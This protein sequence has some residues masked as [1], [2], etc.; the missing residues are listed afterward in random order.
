MLNVGP[1]MPSSCQSGHCEDWVYL[2]TLLAVFCGLP[3][4]V[5]CTICQYGWCIVCTQGQHTPSVCA[6]AISAF[7]GVHIDQLGCLSGLCTQVVIRIC[8]VHNPP[9]SSGSF[10]DVHTI[11]PVCTPPINSDVPGTVHTTDPICTPF[12]RSGTLVI[13]RKTICCNKAIYK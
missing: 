6:Q 2:Y 11:D 12:M 3:Q 7:C 9:T 10:V 5:V 1:T 13:E 8:S 4:P